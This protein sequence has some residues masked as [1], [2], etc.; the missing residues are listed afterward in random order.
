[1]I[2]QEAALPL[3]VRQLPRQIP[4]GGPILGRYVNEGERDDMRYGGTLTIDVE[5]AD[6]SINL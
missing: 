6:Q 1:M 3:V 4:H 5:A 2:R